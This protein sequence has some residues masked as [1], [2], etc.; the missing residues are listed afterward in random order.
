MTYNAG[1]TI[2]FPH[3][4]SNVG[5]GWSEETN[6]FT[7]PVTGY[8][9]VTVSLYKNWEV[10]SNNYQC[11][12]DLY[13]AGSYRLRMDNYDR[14]PERVSYTSSTHAILPC[15]QGEEIWM[16]MG[17]SCR[18]YDSSSHLNQFSGLLVKP[19]LE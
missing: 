17:D 18:L 15:N 1:D 2:R 10:N 19:G 16:R 5:D 8:Y 9:L 6:T 4:F 12:A 3:V 7:C 13:Q 14:T 11:Q